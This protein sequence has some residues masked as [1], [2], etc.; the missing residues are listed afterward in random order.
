LKVSPRRFEVVDEE[1]F[2][3][4]SAYETPTMALA[5]EQRVVVAFSSE[6]FEVYYRCLNQSLKG[7]AGRSSRCKSRS[8]RPLTAFPPSSRP[9]WP[10]S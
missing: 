6:L 2:F 3:G 8:R 4:F 5:A 9:R 1:A 7:P 10:R